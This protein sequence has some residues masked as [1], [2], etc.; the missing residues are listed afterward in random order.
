MKKSKREALNGFV[1]IA[2]NAISAI[3][4]IMDDEEE[5]EI[6]ELDKSE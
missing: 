2:Q 1:K 6:T 3:T 4:A 5:G